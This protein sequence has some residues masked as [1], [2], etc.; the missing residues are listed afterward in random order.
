M[1]RQEYMRNYSK[2][3]Y[4]ENADK[5]RAKSKEWYERNKDRVK[6]RALKPEVKAMKAEADKRYWAKASNAAKETR[7]KAIARWAKNNP[8]KRSANQKQRMF[9]IKQATPQWQCLEE[10]EQ[11]YLNRPEGM[12]VD[13]II[14]LQGKNVSGLHVISNLQYLTMINNCKKS[15]KHLER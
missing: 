10:L 9:K 3:Y 1:T 15:N 6:E 5:M 7:K 8:D 13:H 14:P 4:L 11:F 12:T 2:T